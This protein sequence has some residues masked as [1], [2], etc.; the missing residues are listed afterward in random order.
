MRHTFWRKLATPILFQGCAFKSRRTFRFS[1]LRAHLSQFSLIGALVLNQHATLS[2]CPYNRVGS[3]LQFGPVRFFKFVDLRSP[4]AEDPNFLLSENRH[5]EVLLGF[6]ERVPGCQELLGHPRMEHCFVLGLVRYGA[7]ELCCFPPAFNIVVGRVHQ[8]AMTMPMGI[9][10]PAYRARSSVD[11]TRENCVPG[12]PIMISA[13]GAYPCLY[14][15]FHIIQGLPHRL[16]H[17]L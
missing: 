5:L 7:P 13:G 15:L 9:N 3:L 17:E 12:R 11:K 6:A 10:L 1:E 14:D 16:V 2:A 8:K 4:F